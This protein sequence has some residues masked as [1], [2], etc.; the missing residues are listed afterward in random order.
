MQTKRIDVSRSV[1]KRKTCRC[2]SARSDG[3]KKKNAAGFTYA[4]KEAGLTYLDL[5]ASGY[6]DFDEN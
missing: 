5:V 1:P 3:F 4:L 2:S 6:R